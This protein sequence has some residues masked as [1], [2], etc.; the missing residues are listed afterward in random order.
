MT[1]FSYD[2]SFEGLLCCIYEAYERKSFPDLLSAENAPFP[3]FTEQQVSIRTD[4][5]RSQRVWRGLQKKI[6]P[7]ALSAIILTWQSELPESDWLLFQYIRKIF[8]T[9]GST[10]LNFGDP[11]VL[12]VAHIA[13]KVQQERHRIIQFLRFQKT[14]DGIFFAAVEPLYNVLPF[15]I[16][17]F[18]DRFAGQTWLI[19]DMKRDYGYYY[20][21]HEVTEVRFENEKPHLPNGQPDKT[22]LD[23]QEL[24]LQKMWKTYFNS[25]CIR[26]RSNPKLH[27]QNLPVRF[28]KY[29]P[30]KKQ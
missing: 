11:V 10:E 7:A 16:E 24:L 19:Y 22:V 25:I 14:A 26:E 23:Q 12:K 30:E 28:W 18:R 8:E 17:H 6:S 13:K 9:N 29:L 15:A 20:N 3:L 5:K 4:E 2:Q 1:V 27:R 21:Q